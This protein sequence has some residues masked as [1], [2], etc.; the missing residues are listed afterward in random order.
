MKETIKIEEN[1]KSIQYALKNGSF[2]RYELEYISIFSG[3]LK[4]ETDK[5]IKKVDEK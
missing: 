5:L 3:T 2:T 4:E 1:L